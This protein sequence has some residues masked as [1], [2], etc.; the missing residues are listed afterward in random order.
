VALSRAR[1]RSK[2][3]GPREDREPRRAAPRG[4]QAPKAGPPR[5]GWEFLWG[6]AYNS[7]G[8]EQSNLAAEWWNTGSWN[9]GYI[10]APN[11]EAD[12]GTV[13]FTW[14]G[15]GTA[16]G[17]GT[18][19]DGGFFYLSPADDGAVTAVMPN[20]GNGV[21]AYGGSTNQSH[22]PIM[23]QVTGFFDGST[24]HV[25]YIDDYG[26]VVELY[27]AASS[28]SGSSIGSW[29]YHRIGGGGNAAH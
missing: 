5:G 21:L 12:S 27:A 23:N 11:I 16:L 9:F 22:T 7:S 18:G 29:T 14:T 15:T 19:S 10:S 2:E 17:G 26:Y 20:H 28:V 1:A 24:L 8:T 13:A 3:E 25:Y 6:T 4:T